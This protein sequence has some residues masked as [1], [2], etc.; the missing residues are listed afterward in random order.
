M[1]SAP[2]LRLDGL[3]RRFDT[4]TAV[5]HLDLEVPAGSV[6][7]FLGPN[8]A[9]KTTTIRLA[10][11]L[12]EPTAGRAEVLGRDVATDGGSPRLRCAPRAHRFVRTALRVR[13]SRV[14]RAPVA[15]AR[16]RARRADPRAA[17]ALRAGGSA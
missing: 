5:D 1:A 9:G 11:G 2:A 17:G 6:F 13:Q 16:R 8:G 14:L 12:L 4:V 7:G 3:T 10:L 15:D